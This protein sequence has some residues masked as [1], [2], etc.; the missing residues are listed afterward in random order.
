G[1]GAD[2]G[3]DG[4]GRADHVPALRHALLHRLRDAGPGEP[5][6]QHRRHLHD[7]HAGEARVRY[8]VPLH[9]SAAEQCGAGDP[10]GADLINFVAALQTGPRLT[11]TLSPAVDLASLPKGPV[12]TSMKGQVKAGTDPKA[13][14]DDLTLTAVMTAGAAPL[15]LDGTQDVLLRF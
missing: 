10:L 1:P 8:V 6:W 11:C 7:V 2:H 3:N 12:L 5:R 9:R 15:A 13:A 4:L 14:D